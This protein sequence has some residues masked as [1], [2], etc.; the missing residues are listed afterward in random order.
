ML[1]IG[2]MTI[3]EL[4]FPG[5]SRMSP[6]GPPTF[7]STYLRQVGFMV[8]P[9]SVVGVDFKPALRLYEEFGVDLSRVKVDEACRTTRFRIRYSA[10][11]SRT[12][13]LIN[14]CRDIKGEDLVID[15]DTVVVDPVAGE[16]SWRL[17]ED[18]RGKVRLMAIDLQGFTRRFMEDGLVLNSGDSEAIELALRYA[19]VVK[20]SA[21]EVN[22]SLINPGDKVL[23]VS[24]GGRLAKMYTRGR[25][26]WFDGTVRVNT[27]DPT[28]AGDVLVCSLTSYLKVGLNPVDAFIRAVALSTVRVTVNGP[29]GRV[30]PWLLDHVTSELNRLIRYSVI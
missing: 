30:D 19:D 4:E 26:Y 3:D 16:V 12:L 2:H 21:D 22:Q 27:V 10:D 29:F 17:V 11:M 14:R 13:W 23:V 28:G 7:C 18:I 20:V 5:V 6:G 9:I 15:E 8:K 1:V 24:M 25:V